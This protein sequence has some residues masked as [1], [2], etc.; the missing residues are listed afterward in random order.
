MLFQITEKGTQCP[1]ALKYMNDN[2]RCV[3]SECL[4]RTRKE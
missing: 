1:K 4:S 3:Q 2:P